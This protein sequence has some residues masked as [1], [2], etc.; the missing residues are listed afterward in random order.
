MCYVSMYAFLLDVLNVK[1]NSGN[2]LV[3]Y[4][5]FNCKIPTMTKQKIVL[6]FDFTT[7]ILLKIIIISKYYS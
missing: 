7:N 2:L 4:I 1:N 5:L 6:Y 3:E